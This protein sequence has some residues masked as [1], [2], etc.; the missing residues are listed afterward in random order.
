MSGVVIAVY[1]TDFLDIFIIN[2]TLTIVL[3]VVATFGTIFLQRERM[4]DIT[5]LNFY[6]AAVFPLFFFL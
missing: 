4:A 2:K 1:K 6:T 3:S 5:L